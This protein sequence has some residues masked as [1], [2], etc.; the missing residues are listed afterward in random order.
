MRCKGGNTSWG[1][2][3]H[4]A[5]N[6]NTS[7]GYECAEN[8]DNTDIKTLLWISLYYEIFLVHLTFEVY[9]A[10][11]DLKNTIFHNEM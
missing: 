8:K 11:S 3:G 4:I 9:S 5:L 2:N 6:Q 7:I 10:R 1:R